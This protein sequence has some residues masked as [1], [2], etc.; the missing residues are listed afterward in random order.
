MTPKD[1]RVLKDKHGEHPA[2]DAGQL[3]LL[4]MFLVLWAAD[5][6]FLGWT[7]FPAS[8]VPLLYRLVTS[9][10]VLLWGIILARASHSI[11]HHDE[12]PESVRS[13]G[14]FRFIR[15]PLY[16][17]SMLFYIALTLMSFSL[18]SLGMTVVIFI[19]YDF[20]ARHE[21]KLMIKRFGD[22]YRDYMK[23]T[24]RWMPRP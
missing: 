8:Y 9:G 24:G 11:T 1:G 14:A 6:F 13:S 17:S 7:T 22:E 2:G 15:H 19:F 23:S 21:E 20:L 5:S 4:F 10:A 18:A 3:V 16:F 12:G